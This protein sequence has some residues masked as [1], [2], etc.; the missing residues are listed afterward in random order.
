VLTPLS[1]KDL[2]YKSFIQ[3][4]GKTMKMYMKQTKMTKGKGMKKGMK[5]GMK[6]GMKSGGKKKK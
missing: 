3:Q 2:A 6:K 1:R 4:K 5:T